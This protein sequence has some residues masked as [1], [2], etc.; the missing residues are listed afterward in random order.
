M[1]DREDRSRATAW[2]GLC[3]DAGLMVGPAIT[4]LLLIFVDLGRAKP[5]PEHHTDGP[6]LLAQIRAG[7]EV[8]SRLPGV[9][10]IVVAGALAMLA[11]ALMNPA[12]P[13]LAIGPLHGGGGAYAVL[14][15]CY[16]IGMVGGTL[17]NSRLTSD[18]SVLRRRWLAG[19]ALQTAG[20]AGS[21]LAPDLRVAA[22][23][24]LL[25]GVGNACIAGPEMRMLQE[26]VPDG[27]LGRTLGLYDVLGNAAYAVA[28]V[29][30]GGLL[31]YLGPRTVLATGTV[32][33]GLVLVG[34]AARLG[35]T[36]AGAR[37][38]VP[39]AG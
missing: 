18:V 10:I 13:L 6:S 34:A 1:V 23:T 20:M 38:P 17:V 32:L 31:S 36:A 24:F 3:S 28:F 12:E 2:W 16:G 29:G 5:P 33:V 9:S 11:A 19:M 22:L 37:M 25:T 39:E 27:L 30:A 7:V 8:V 26:L 21:A 15:G 35:L 4:A 14:V